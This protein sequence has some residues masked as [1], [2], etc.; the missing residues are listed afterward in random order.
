MTEEAAVEVG[1]PAAITLAIDPSLVG[2][3]LLGGDP[4]LAGDPL[5]VVEALLFSKNVEPDHT[6]NILVQHTSYYIWNLL[7]EFPEPPEDGSV[8]GLEAMIGGGEGE[9]VDR[10][11]VA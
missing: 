8:E 10:K 3:P 4:L 9:D 5:M 11:G 1:R 2:S 7:L 6:F